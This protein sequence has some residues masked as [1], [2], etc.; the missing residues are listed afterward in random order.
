MRLFALHMMAKHPAE[1]GSLDLLDALQSDPN[2]K[3][4]T[5]ARYL[6]PAIRGELDNTDA[7]PERPWEQEGDDAEAGGE[8]QAEEVIEL[9]E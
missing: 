2:V 3:L 1:L 6:N 4:R 9:T 7:A 8:V 5:E